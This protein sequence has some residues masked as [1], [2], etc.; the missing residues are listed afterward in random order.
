M[1][2]SAGGLDHDGPVGQFAQERTWIP[3]EGVEGEAVGGDDRN[4]WLDCW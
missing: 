2:I 3:C 1:A 4:L